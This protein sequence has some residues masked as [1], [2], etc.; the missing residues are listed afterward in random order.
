MSRPTFRNPLPLKLA[1]AVAGLPDE[2]LRA[3]MAAALAPYYAPPAYTCQPGEV[4]RDVASVRRAF[5]LAYRDGLVVMNDDNDEASMVA[6]R[7]EM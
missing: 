3:Q 4:D 1:L 6:M 2:K 5:D 7:K